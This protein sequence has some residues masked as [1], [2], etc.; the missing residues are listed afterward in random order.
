MSQKTVP[1]GYMYLYSIIY[2]VVTRN[3]GSEFE[4]ESEEWDLGS[5]AFL[6][7]RDQAISFLWDTKMGSAMKKHTSQ[8]RY[9][10][11]EYPPPP[12]SLFIA[13][14]IQKNSKQIILV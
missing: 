13:T 9:K 11:R 5:A 8:P 4:G 14:I 12:I 3:V 10:I 1:W 2:T 7:I 6:G